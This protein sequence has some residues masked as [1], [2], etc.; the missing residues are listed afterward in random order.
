VTDRVL[1]EGV[2]NPESA[3]SKN[4][5]SGK[6]RVLCLNEADGRVIWQRSY[7]STYEVSYAAGPRATPVVSGD[8]VYTLGTMGHLFCFNVSTGKVLWSKNFI[9]DYGARV[10]SWGFAA[11][12]LIDGDKLICLVGGKDGL[13]AAFNKDT[14]K[15]LW[16]AL[17]TSETGYCPPMIY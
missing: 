2:Q 13:V 8:K 5:V 15:E 6:E 10:P 14:G 12:P 16:W 7:D 9:E 4:A 17:K 1:A 3:F 11:H